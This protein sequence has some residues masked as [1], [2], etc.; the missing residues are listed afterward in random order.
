MEV[1][2]TKILGTNTPLLEYIALKDVGH[3]W[4]TKGLRRD[5]GKYIQCF[6]KSSDKHRVLPFFMFEYTLGS[7]YAFLNVFRDNVLI[8][9]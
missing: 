8:F 7:S 1:G 4:F 6:N 2:F 3:I 9:K 5:C